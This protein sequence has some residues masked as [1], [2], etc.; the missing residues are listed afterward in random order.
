[1]G[2]EQGAGVS[3]VSELSGPAKIMATKWGVQVIEQSIFWHKITK[4]KFPLMG[5]F[6]TS[7]LKECR[8]FLEQYEKATGKSK[9]NIDWANFRKWEREAECREERQ[10]KALL[11]KDESDEEKHRR[12]RV[13]KYRE[14]TLPPP[15]RCSQAAQAQP[16]QVQLPLQQALVLPPPIVPIPQQAL[17]V[18]PQ[19]LVPQILPVNPA[20]VLYAAAALQAHN[21]EVKVPEITFAVEGAGGQMDM[22][23][24]DKGPMVKPSV[25]DIDRDL[26]QIGEGV[27]GMTLRSKANQQKQQPNQLLP[28]ISYPNPHP[29]PPADADPA[30]RAAYSDIVHVQ[31]N[32]TPDELSDIVKELP[33]PRNDVEQWCTAVLDLIDMYSPSAR[34][35]ESVFRKNFGLKWPR[36]RGNYDVNGLRNDIVTG[37]LQNND[38]LF[39][40]V[41]AAY[42][43]R[44]DWPK[45]HNTKQLLDE[46][47]DVYR[48]RM[49]DC[50]Q[51]HCGVTQDNPAYND[52]LKT[53][54]INGLLPSI[55]DRV[56]T[57]C[58]SWESR[59]LTEVWG[60]AQHAE[61]FVISR[62]DTRKR[63]LEVAQ[64]MFYDQQM[65][66]QGKEGEKKK[67]T[68]GK[69]K[70]Y[71]KT[72]TDRGDR[73][74]YCGEPGH[75]RRECAVQA[76]AWKHRPQQQQQQNSQ[77]GGAPWGYAAGREDRGQGPW[78]EGQWRGGPPPP[79]A[80][81]PQIGWYPDN[82]DQERQGYPYEQQGERQGGTKR[83]RDHDDQGGSWGPHYGPGGG[84]TVTNPRL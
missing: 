29:P 7:K 10:V 50:F 33:N 69:Q 77:Q 22:R 51:K 25:A 24:E 55:H 75:F 32:W 38:G 14:E 61:R 27:H 54:L 19:D 43:M 39:P 4:A 13:K 34:E 42:P 12:K 65:G 17:P 57:S 11:Y 15:Y 83:Q 45:I 71:G 66:Q 44:T 67:Y 40:R 6:S 63:K 56:M 28:L 84:V 49:E 30:V 60:H 2:N 18:L 5:T 82:R 37:Q 46:S 76:K 9:K 74:Y 35:L 20:G 16:D 31:R 23:G 62:D 64:L 53:A 73:C 47:C 8:D 78:R 21:A 70:G 68:Q 79:H 72:Q 80:L 1:M 48:S 41:R 58:V 36:L 81:R 26:I 3:A 52:L 59:P